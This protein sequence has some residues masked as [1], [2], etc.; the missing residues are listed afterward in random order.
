M[1]A[2]SEARNRACDDFWRKDLLEKR[3]SGGFK[4]IALES[5]RRPNSMKCSNVVGWL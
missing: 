3:R 1:D 4:K 2:R 5:G